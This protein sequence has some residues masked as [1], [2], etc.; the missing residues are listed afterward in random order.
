MATVAAAG[1]GDGGSPVGVVTGESTGTAMIT[2]ESGGLSASATVE[3]VEEPVYRVTIEPAPVELE[4]EEMK[5]LTATVYDEESMELAGRPVS[6]S[7]TNTDVVTVGMMSGELEGLKPGRAEIVARSEGVEARAAVTVTEKSVD[8]VEIVPANAKMVARGGTLQLGALPVDRRGMPLCTEMEATGTETPCGR[9]A[10]WTSGAASIATVDDKGLVTGQ[11][12]GTV[13]IFADVDGTRASREITVTQGN[14]VPLADAGPDQ[15]AKVGDMVQLDG[16]GSS[17]PNMSQSLSYQW[18][19]TS[20]PA[21]STAMLTGPKTAKPSLTVDKAGAY[22]VELTVSDGKLSAT[23][24]VRI[25]VTQPS[26][27]PVADAGM[28]QTVTAGTTVQLDA[29]GSS[30]PDVEPLTYT[31]SF[32]SRPMGSTAALSNTFIAKPTLTTDVAGTYELQV[33]VDDGTAVDTDTVV[34][35]AVASGGDV[36]MDA[37]DV[38]SDTSAGRDAGMDAGMDAGSDGGGDTTG[39]MD[40][41]DSG[42]GSDTS[43]ETGDSGTASMDVDATAD[44]GETDI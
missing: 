28:D 38:A 43:G 8:T 37:A 14:I 44:S 34:V 12:P 11:K 4:V 9:T 27:P 22:V 32:V 5:S 13:T 35:T 41:A 33:M 24:S 29:S 18:G 10:T 42:S 21:G 16:S 31:W 40:A 6:W 23:D 3:V 19:F 36:G 25:D 2:V 7:S 1:D 20:K 26:Q 17:D 15:T 39:G 30:D